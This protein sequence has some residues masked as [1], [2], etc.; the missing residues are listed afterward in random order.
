[1][2]GNLPHFSKYNPRYYEK[3]LK[4]ITAV[5]ESE[6]FRN[7]DV[8][9]KL[10]TA[11]SQVRDATDFAS[12]VIRMGYSAVANQKELAGCIGL[13]S[14][15]LDQF[16]E[17]VELRG[18]I[19]DVLKDHSDF[20]KALGAGLPDYSFFGD[21]AIFLPEIVPY[22]GVSVA[23][24]EMRKFHNDKLKDEV[25][26][27]T[28]LI[29]ITDLEYNREDGGFLIALSGGKVVVELPFCKR[30]MTF[31]DGTNAHCAQADVRRGLKGEMFNVKKIGELNEM[32]L[33]QMSQRFVFGL[34]CNRYVVSRMC[35]LHKKYFQKK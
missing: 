23:V 3:I 4:A 28:L 34:Y 20:M 10:L 9:Q 25:G 33:E 19:L 22:T 13:F 21:N 14:K 30:S 2:G 11:A 35:N 32:H 16:D 26:S 12:F 24:R 27:L 17:M 18:C 7:N 31:F 5:L 1:L 29:C 8:V 6:A 15:S